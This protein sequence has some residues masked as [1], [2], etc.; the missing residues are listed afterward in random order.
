MLVSIVDVK[1]KERLSD[2]SKKRRL[3]TKVY[4]DSLRGAKSCGEIGFQSR[5]AESGERASV[6]RRRWA[7]HREGSLV[8]RNVDGSQRLKRRKLP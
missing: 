4:M 1:R 5:R 3:A 2:E 6:A 8:V 7:Q